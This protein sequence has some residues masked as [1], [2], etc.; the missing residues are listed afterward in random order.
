M[1]TRII[2]AIMLSVSFL[3]ACQENEPEVVAQLNQLPDISG[4]PIVGTNQS[5]SFDNFS[6]IDK[7]GPGE[8]F[9]GQNSNYPGNSPAYTDNGDGTVTDNITGLMWQQSFDH[10]KDGSIDYSDKLTYEEILDL[11]DEGASFAGYDDWRL[12]S[13]KEMYS[14]ILFSGRDIS[15]QSTSTGNL[16]PFIDNATFAF[17]YGD[18]NAGERLIDMQC[19]TTTVYDSDEVNYMLFGVNFADGRI[20]AYGTEFPG[21]DKKAFNYLLVRGNTSYG[22]NQFQDNG[23][24]TISDLATGL[25]W[26][27]NDNGEGI[28]W[29]DALTYAEGTD[30][31]GYSDWRLPDAKEL[32]SIVD[33]ERSPAAT[34]SA[35]IN[36]MFSCSEIVNEAGQD[37]FPWYWSSTTH[38]S[39]L[40]GSAAAYVA[41]GR[42]LG[43]MWGWIDIHGAGSQRSDPKVGNPEEYAN[44][45]GPQG[46][47]IRIY[48]YVRLVRNIK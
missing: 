3:G 1:K 23:D 19:A 26:Q 29:Q 32:Q 18:L 5:T 20:K 41:F 4:Y 17:D 46:D 28:L 43:N 33:Y 45:R 37:D 44:G 38:A 12:P 22:K 35:A 24:G 8:L 40:S 25:M 9:Y 21:G 47:A 10:N 13:I 34:G 7:P 30:F 27:Q 42:S 2:I 6:T 39:Q 11:V 31:A 14:L 36:P 15:P 16:V 48:N